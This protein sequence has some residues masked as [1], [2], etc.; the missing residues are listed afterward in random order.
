MKT[1][2]M[3]D[4]VGVFAKNLSIPERAG[5]DKKKSRRANI[6]PDEFHRMMKSYPLKSSPDFCSFPLFSILR[7]AQCRISVEIFVRRT[8][9]IWRTVSPRL[10]STLYNFG[11]VSACNKPIASSAADR[12]EGFLPTRCRALMLK[13]TR[14]P[15]DVVGPLPKHH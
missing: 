12:P 13:N 8:R 9:T 3:R 14:P 6:S 4:A 11:Q 5:I 2:W 10:S 15:T 1:S 7:R